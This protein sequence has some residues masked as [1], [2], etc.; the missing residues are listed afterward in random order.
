MKKTML[1]L[2]VLL[3]CLTGLA[4]KNANHYPMV[5]LGGQYF[6]TERYYSDGDIRF[7][8]QKFTFSA[9]ASYTGYF[10]GGSIPGAQDTVKRRASGDVYEPR[11]YSATQSTRGNANVEKVKPYHT[12][13]MNFS[14]TY[15]K[16]YEKPN[17]MNDYDRYLDY[18]DVYLASISVALR[19]K[20][21]DFMFVYENPGIMGGMWFAGVTCDAGVM[22]D[23]KYATL[24]VGLK[25]SFG[26]NFMVEMIDVPTMIYFGAGYSF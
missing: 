26:Y 3:I 21:N 18:Y 20:I 23:F 1:I 5:V 19:Q 24:N 25:V 2:F 12:V 9:G 14:T 6:D 7:D 8:G 15:S 17:E 4:A 13:G 10:W 11:R 16:F 22:F